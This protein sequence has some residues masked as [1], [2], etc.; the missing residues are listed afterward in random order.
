MV[1][2]ELMDCLPV[3]T[4]LVIVQNDEEVKLTENVFFYRIIQ[5]YL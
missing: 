2:A 5:I 3:D 1:V 4:K